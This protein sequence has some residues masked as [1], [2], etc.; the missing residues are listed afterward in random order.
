M[1]CVQSGRDL[2][3]HLFEGRTAYFYAF[4]AAAISQLGGMMLHQWLVPLSQAA[5]IFP[6]FLHCIRSNR[7]KQNFKLMAFWSLCMTL[8]SIGLTLRFSEQAGREYLLGI[9]YKT[10]MFR[11]IETGLGPE[12]DYRLFVPQHLL[13]FGIF[14]VAALVSGGFL[15]L[16]LGAALLNYMSYYVGCLLLAASTKW[17]LFLLGW[18]PYAI[19]R[20]LGYILLAI[21]CAHHFYYRLLHYSIDRL[22]IRRFLYYGLML[23]TLDII[24][25]S[26]FAEPWRHL[27]KALL[28]NSNL[29]LTEL[30][31][32]SSFL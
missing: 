32:L 31:K 7:P 29:H 22:L 15:A 21:V 2:K 28:G 16:V 8:S 18:P 17:P 14:S 11:W 20:V 9:R 25:K 24:T 19:L 4:L 23:V 27:L 13:Q 6:L 5:F 26:L 1:T 3:L 10:E 12:G 30:F